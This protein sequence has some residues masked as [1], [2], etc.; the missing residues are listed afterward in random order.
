MVLN[1]KLRAIR[2]SS[3]PKNDKQIKIMNSGMTV[4]FLIL[5]IGTLKAQGD[6]V[7]DTVLF[8]QKV[9]RDDKMFEDAFK[10]K[11]GILLLTSQKMEF[12]SKRPSHA[13]FDFS[14]P[15]NEIQSIRTFYGFV[16]PNRIRIRTK[17]GQTYR[18]FTYKKRTIIK[19]TRGQM[20]SIWYLPSKNLDVS[21]LS[22]REN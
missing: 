4:A 22:G 20:A 12:K 18:L 11:R 9:V 19:I 15:Y 14:I 17:A 8:S 16:I 5:T 21:V 2:Y 7:K 10:T 3:E 1:S 6:V 13:R